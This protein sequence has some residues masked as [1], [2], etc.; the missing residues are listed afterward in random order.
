MLGLATGPIIACRELGQAFDASVLE[1]VFLSTADTILTA[2]VAATAI[3]AGLP[4][5]SVVMFVTGIATG[6]TT[7]IL[8]APGVT[9]QIIDAGSAAAVAAYVNPFH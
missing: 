1:D 5:T 7:L 6:N 9:P 8:S 3:K 4:A 2:N